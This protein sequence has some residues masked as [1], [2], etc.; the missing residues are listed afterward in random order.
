MSRK[1][2]TQV[3]PD[4][5]RKRDM[6]YV[7]SELLSGRRQ[8]LWAHGGPHAGRRG[9]AGGK[10]AALREWPTARI[11]L[12]HEPSLK[13]DKGYSYSVNGSWSLRGR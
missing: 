5:I 11:S 3:K 4:Q 12:A 6:T 9:F 7:W 1:A 8:T 13:H 10:A 2:F